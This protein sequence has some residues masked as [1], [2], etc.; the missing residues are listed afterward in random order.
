MTCLNCE[1]PACWKAAVLDRFVDQVA[2]G[3]GCWEWTGSRQGG[4]RGSYGRLSVDGRLV[5]AHRVSWE[6]LVGQIPEGLF[7][8]HHC[9]NPGCVRPTHLFL[10]T[11]A[12]N[13]DDASR[14]GRIHGAKLTREQVVE[15][16]ASDLPHAHFAKLFGVSL[17]AIHLARSGVTFRSVPGAWPHG[18]K[19]TYPKRP[20]GFRGRFMEGA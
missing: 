6:L 4:P 14:K 18:K 8:C 16:R 10:G 15:A 12:D 3:P 1:C 13:A 19:P 17:S 20:R 2:V 7:V 9:D 5:G 11:A